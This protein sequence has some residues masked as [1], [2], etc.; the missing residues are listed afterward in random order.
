MEKKKWNIVWEPKYLN[1]KNSNPNYESWSRRLWKWQGVIWNVFGRYADN[2]SFN[3]WCQK[4]KLFKV[5][6]E[7]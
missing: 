7:C 4:K 2:F 3:Y 5:Q 6:L 1:R